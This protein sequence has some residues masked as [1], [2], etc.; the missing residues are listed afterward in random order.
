VDLIVDGKRAYAYTA[1]HALDTALPSVV[2]VHGAANDHS[3]F[4]LQ[5][6]YFAYHRCN[7]LAVD[8]PGHGRSAGPPLATIATMADWLA[9]LLDAAGI[10]TAALVGHSMGSLVTLECAA[11]HP[12]RARVLALIGTSAPMPVGDALMAAAHADSHAA[13]D[14][15]NI[16]GHS[17]AAQLGGN[18]VPGMWMTGAYVRLL[19]RAKP[20][21]LHVDL[22]ACADYADGL[23]SAARVMCPT[24]FVLGSRDALTPPR[25]A[26]D[27]R[28]AL[29]AARVV[30]LDGAGH[31][32]LAERPDAVLDA[33]IGFV[34]ASTGA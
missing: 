5:S 28:T 32:L 30:M 17:A 16:W 22:R 27:L 10:R 11:R 4:L 34:D 9:S 19:E 7:A 29:P 2:F 25:N 23:A 31:A 3:A 12:E 18:T 26:G 13:L 24:L 6:R 21:V 20:Q 15:L 33:L 8:L 14:M 1:G